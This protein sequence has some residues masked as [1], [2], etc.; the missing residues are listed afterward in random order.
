MPDPQISAKKHMPI[1]SSWRCQLTLLLTAWSLPAQTTALRGLD[2]VALCGGEELAGSTDFVVERGRYRYQFANAANRTSFE[3]EPERFEIQLDGACA[4]MGPLSG[5]GDP[6][7]FHVHRQRIYIFASDQCRDGFVKRHDAFLATEEPAPTDAAA[8]AAGRLLVERAARAHGGVERLRQWTSYYHEREEQK[9]DTTQRWRTHL[10]LPATARFDHDYTQGKQTWR[11]ANVLVGGTSAFALVGD[12]AQPLGVDAK[13]ELQRSLAAEPLVALRL[14]L[15]GAAVAVPAGKREVAGIAV[16]EFA[17]WCH[18]QSVA[19]GL[20]NDDRVRTSRCRSRAPGM[21]FGAVD[22][23]F[24]DHREHGGLTVP[25]SVQGFFEG[26]EAPALH[27]QRR[28][29]VIDSALPD[30]LFVMPAK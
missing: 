25:G 21:W 17:V 4:R 29:I 9:D 5:S 2:P 6:Q 10:R 3:R 23:V 13:R 12:K 22:R 20:G 15:D 8:I 24:A 27:E 26:K 1:L 19:F 16:E 18:G 14:V 7:R 11:N 30:S 28:G